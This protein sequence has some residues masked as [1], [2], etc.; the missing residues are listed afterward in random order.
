[1]PDLR[2]D[3]D[4]L[5]FSADK[6][7]KSLVKTINTSLE[8]FNPIEL[9][10]LTLAGFIVLRYIL[11]KLSYVQ[12]TGLKTILFRLVIKLPFISGKAS[13]EGNKVLVEYTEKFKA[14]RPNATK[15]LPLKGVPVD[16]IMAKCN[17][18]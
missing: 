8:P 3:L 4:I 11:E 1:M 14:Q 5:L 13:Q 9:I 2:K 7:C 17:K 15:V 16:T 6:H 18:G 10:I 12:K